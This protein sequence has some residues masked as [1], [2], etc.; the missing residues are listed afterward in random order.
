MTKVI[1]IKRKIVLQSKSKEEVERLLE[2]QR[3]Q[4]LAERDATYCP[5]V[6][7]KCNIACE[8]LSKPEIQ[9][10][11]EAGKRKFSWTKEEI[12]NQ[13]TIYFTVEA[14]YTCTC[15]ALKGE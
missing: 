3:P 8:C 11:Y 1:N 15:F 4:M 13:E 14:E 10:Y 2:E 5:L 9:R 7:G 6:R 12:A